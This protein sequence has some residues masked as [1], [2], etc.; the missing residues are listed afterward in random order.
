[1]SLH[2]KLVPV[3]YRE[4]EY[5]LL[6]VGVTKLQVWLKNTDFGASCKLHGFCLSFDWVTG[7]FVSF[8]IGWSNYFGFGFTTLSI[9]NRSIAEV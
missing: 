7:S 9:E 8:V 2:C 5:G 1:M 3:Q 4:Y 6:V